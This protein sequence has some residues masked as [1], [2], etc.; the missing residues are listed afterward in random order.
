MLHHIACTLTNVGT[1]AS[2]QAAAARQSAA[3][4]ARGG[5]K[6]RQTKVRLVKNQN[7]A[8]RY[9]AAGCAREPGSYWTAVLI[10]PPQ[11]ICVVA[12]TTVGG[13]F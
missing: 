9:N 7:E 5:I 6:L 11:S 13:P 3:G 2:S 10:A 12:E 8:G 4:T 1:A